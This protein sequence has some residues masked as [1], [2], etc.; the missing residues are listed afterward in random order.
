MNLKSRRRYVSFNASDCPL[1]ICT[2]IFFE[3]D[4][5]LQVNQRNVN[6]QNELA[7]DRQ[8][9]TTERM[10]LKTMKPPAASFVIAPL[11]ESCPKPSGAP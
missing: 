2:H 5:V 6:V 9:S 11:I 8:N 10:A 1:Q 3:Y 4:F 7:C